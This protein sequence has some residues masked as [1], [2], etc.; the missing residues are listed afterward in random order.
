MAGR[1]QLLIIL[2]F[3]LF[4]IEGTVVPWIIPDSWLPRIGHNFVFIAILFVTVYYHRHSALVLGIIFGLLHDVVFYGHMI[5]PYSFAMGLT[6]YLIGLFFKSPRATMPVMMMMVI[7][8]SLL[9]D[10]ILFFTYKLFRLNQESYNWALLEYM[11]PTVFIHFIFALIIYVP[12]R[13]QLDRLTR[14]RVTKKDKV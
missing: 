11:I 5:G 10:T 14:R 3:V 12:L 9:F 7:L 13:K 4:I 1:K 2:L 8:G 6:A